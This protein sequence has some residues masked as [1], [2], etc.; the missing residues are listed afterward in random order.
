MTEISSAY[1]EMEGPASASPLHPADSQEKILA[2]LPIPSAMSSILGSCII[3][4]MALSSRKHR[5]WSP[6]TRLLLAMSIYSI[7]SSILL[8][9][10][11]FV[12][13]QETSPRLLSFGNK[14]TCS[15]VGFL[16]QVSYAS[17]FYNGVL[18][19][20]FLLTARYGLSNDYIASKLEV[21]AHIFSIGYPLGCAC[22]AAGLGLFGE[23]TSGIGCWVSRTPDCA[24]NQHCLARILPWICYGM[25]GI[26]VFLV[27]VTNNTIISLYVR[28]QT[29]PIKAQPKITMENESGSSH[30]ISES[31]LPVQ[32]LP[33]K[34]S[35]RIECGTVLILDDVEAMRDDGMGKE[36]TRRLRLV[37]SQAVLYVIFF[38]L[39]H[40]WSAIIGILE[41][42]SD[43][44]EQEMEVV[45]KSYSIFVLQATLT[46]LQGFFNMLVYIRPKYMKWRHECPKETRLWVVRRAIF[47]TD[48]QPTH[49]KKKKWIPHLARPKQV[50][51][52]ANSGDEDVAK[53]DITSRD[54]TNVPS[55]TPLPRGLVS[56]LTAS[57]GDFD[58]VDD[59]RNN[60]IWIVDDTPE[61]LRGGGLPP[62]TTQ[63]VSSLEFRTSS[64]LDVISEMEESSFEP[65][66]S[67]EFTR[68]MPSLLPEEVRAT[69]AV[70]RWFSDATSGDGNRFTTPSMPLRA[71]EA[72][73]SRSFNASSPDADKPISMPQ[74]RLS[75]PPDST[76]GRVMY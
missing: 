6:Y 28:Q 72:T 23:T 67:T 3:I 1:E 11:A 14:A 42:I 30:S 19:F 38:L 29:R 45:V 53:E 37:F 47:G 5:K 35:R 56:S 4:Y 50:M 12:R 31:G 62:R 57:R 75:P 52:K 40:L 51:E 7:L 73:A 25:P 15:T 2:I 66:V 34:G 49:L 60:E 63:F 13:P 68:T 9:T 46:P 65:I 39:C 8:S 18:S 10:A 22:V 61:V 74:R 24:E 48:V 16:N 41:S 71:N 26:L 17:I 27:L 20:Y 21:P 76:A 43:T 64:V 44:T 33:A 36:Q 58:H 69:K 55:V 32:E 70:Q 59:A 54:L